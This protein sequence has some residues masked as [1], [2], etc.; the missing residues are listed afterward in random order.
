MAEKPITKKPETESRSHS[1]KIEHKNQ[2]SH[3]IECDFQEFRSKTPH[4]HPSKSE[5][6]KTCFI[7]NKSAGP[8]GSPKK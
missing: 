1:S 8:S 6:N 4:S 7:I 5:S 3:K 2:N